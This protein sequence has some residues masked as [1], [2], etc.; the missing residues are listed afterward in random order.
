MSILTN[1]KS[2]LIDNISV[3]QDDITYND[4]LNFG[5]F[6]TSSETKDFTIEITKAAFLLKLNDIYDVVKSEIK[7]DDDM[8]N[9]TSEF[10]KVNYCSLEELL[11]KPTSLFEI[12]TTYLQDPFFVYLTSKNPTFVI[13]SISK[14]IVAND[15]KIQGKVFVKNSF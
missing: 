4:G 8:Y 14:I 11:T 10:S 7:I 9:D 5:R 12:F 3:N 2:I 1:F 15:I 6:T 13:N